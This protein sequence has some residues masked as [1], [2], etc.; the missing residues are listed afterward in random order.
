M[1]KWYNE[2][3]GGIYGYDKLNAVLDDPD[4]QFLPRGVT[5]FALAKCCWLEWSELYGEPWHDRQFRLYQ[6]FDKML[7]FIK[8]HFTG[9]DEWADRAD[10]S[11]WPESPGYYLYLIL[12][13]SG[14]FSRGSRSLMDFVLRGECKQRRRKPGERYEQLEMEV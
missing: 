3:R 8:T 1:L 4:E 2:D 14:K 6:A 7:A 11:A 5:P 10:I 12:D 9:G 13:Q